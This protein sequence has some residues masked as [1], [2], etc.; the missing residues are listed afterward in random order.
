MNGII[1]SSIAFRGDRGLT[2]TGVRS[3]RET[4]GARCTDCSQRRYSLALSRRVR[5]T[6]ACLDASYELGSE[7]AYA[8]VE[9]EMAVGVEVPFSRP[10]RVE[11]YKNDN[12]LSGS[13][14]SSR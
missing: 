11:G 8:F 5:E 4:R 14:H 12:E 10:D 6:K 7:T 9:L 13:Q 3:K 1:A 2:D